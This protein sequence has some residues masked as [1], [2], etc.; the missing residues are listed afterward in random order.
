MMTHAVLVRSSRDFFGESMGI[1]VRGFASVVSD[2]FWWMSAVDF[3]VVAMY[4]L[5]RKTREWH[6]GTEKDHRKG[7]TADDRRYAF[8]RV[9]VMA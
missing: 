1:W 2:W 6:E 4:P 5:I 9:L 8:I 3:D 7:W